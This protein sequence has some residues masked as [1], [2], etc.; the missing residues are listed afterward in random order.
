MKD[1]TRALL[2]VHIC[3]MSSLYGYYSRSLMAYL[4]QLFFVAFDLNHAKICRWIDSRRLMA[5]ALQTLGLVI[6]IGRSL[7]RL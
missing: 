4:F 1:L 5:R 3:M 6:E 2:R 7:K